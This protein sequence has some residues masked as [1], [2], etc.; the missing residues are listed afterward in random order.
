[1]VITN[2]DKVGKMEKVPSGPVQAGHD[3]VLIITLS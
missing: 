1:M 2:G 3:P